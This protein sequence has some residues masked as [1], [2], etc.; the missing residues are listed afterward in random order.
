MS[1]GARCWLVA[2]SFVRIFALRFAAPRS[3]PSHATSP[4]SRAV[5]SRAHPVSSEAARSEA[6]TDTHAAWRCETQDVARE[7][8]AGASLDEI[9][10]RAA[11]LERRVGLVSGERPSRCATHAARSPWPPSVSRWDDAL[12]IELSST[13][14]ANSRI[15]ARPHVHPRSPGS[16]PSLW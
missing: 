1:S 3:A 11:F 14:F 4:M 2:I 16:R 8:A 10:P 5:A 7:E 6:T 13:G 15:R 9:A 12:T